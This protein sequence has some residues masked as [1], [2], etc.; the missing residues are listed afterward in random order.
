M[1]HKRVGRLALLIGLAVIAA[2]VITT[3]GD[4]VWVG[5]DGKTTALHPDA[6]AMFIGDDGERFDLADLADGETRT[7]GRGDKAIT[8][9]RQGDAVT[10]T[11]P[12]VD[13]RR[14]LDM[15]CRLSSDRCQIV[16]FAD[17]PDRVMLIIEKTRECVGGAGDCDVDVD[18]AHLGGTAAHLQLR[19][20]MHCGD[21]G[22]CEEII[23]EIGEGPHGHG[24]VKLEID[25]AG[26]DPDD[27]VVVVRRLGLDGPT[28]FFSD[29]RVALACPEGD[30]TMRVDKEEAED[31]F[32]CPK[33]SVPLERVEHGHGIHR[34]IEIKTDSGGDE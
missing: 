19:K 18:V 29:G 12:A 25:R 5:K 30:T 3:A 23:E 20:M 2:T 6:H 7:F 27:D 11:R 22:E 31:V 1:T 16:T 34:V 15:T 10:L 24:V 14:A 32:L 8:A 9:S 26:V 13:D 21:E 33:H 28:V 4:R 17:D